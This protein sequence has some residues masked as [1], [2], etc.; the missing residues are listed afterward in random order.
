MVRMGITFP[1]LYPNGAA[2][3]FFLDPTTT[4]DITSQQ[5]LIK[6][7]GYMMIISCDYHVTSM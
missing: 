1:S 7:Y 3:S 4:V 6:V 5:E 2:P